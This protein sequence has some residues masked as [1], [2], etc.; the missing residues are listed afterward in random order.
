MWEGEKKAKRFRVSSQTHRRK[1]AP[2]AHPRALSQGRKCWIFATLPRLNLTP[3]NLHNPTRGQ[4][5]CGYLWTMD[6]QLLQGIDGGERGSGELEDRWSSDDGEGI[7]QQKHRR[8]VGGQQVLSL[9][10]S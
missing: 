6:W 2:N 5:V 7:Q 10:D 8:V 3:R 9:E 1:D 4:E